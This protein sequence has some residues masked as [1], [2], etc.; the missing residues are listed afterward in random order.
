MSERLLVTGGTGFLGRHTIAPLLARGVELHG[1]TRGEGGADGV[2]WHRADLLDEGAARALLRDVRPATL[3]HIAWRVEHGKFW[4]APENAVWLE[5]ST[6]LARHFAEAGGRRFI[7]VGT[8]AE[9][10][11][12]AAGDGAP[13]PE[14]RAIQPG[15]P[16]GQAKAELAARLARMPGLATAWARIF[17][18]FGPGEPPARLVPD[19]ALSLLAGREA[20]TGSGRAVR[21]YSCTRF[22]GA[23]LAALALSDVTGAVNVASGEGRPM[24]EIIETI[25]A[26]IG[27]PDLL[28]IGARA[29]PANEVAYMVADTTRL[30]REVGFAERAELHDELAAL[31][32]ALRAPC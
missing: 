31:V 22:V 2:T 30:R 27:R 17:H 32:A 11:D 29:D 8:C 3:L 10:A 18:V 14:S 20:R 4:Q 12:V 23:A 28:R 15:S 9:Y 16:Y 19:V 25:A 13:W 7:G 1:V 26:I 24:R 5:A 21:D 6:A